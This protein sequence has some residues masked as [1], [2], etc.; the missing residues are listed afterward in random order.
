MT[1][2]P[3]EE[4]NHF[5]RACHDAA[6]RGLMRC[7]SGNLSLRL[8]NDQLLVTSSRS[9]MQDISP[10]QVSLCRISD[11]SLL[12]GNKP[13][14]EIGFHAGILRTRSDVNVVMHFQ[15][16]FATTLACQRRDVEPD[17]YVIPEIPFYIGPVARVPYLLPGTPELAQAVTTAMTDHDMVIMGNHGQV[18]VAGDIEHAIQNAEFFELACQAIVTGGQTIRPLH[19]DDVNELL[20]LRNSGQTP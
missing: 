11:A 7:S 20:A 9:W 5:V 1:D 2:I 16:P 6:H 8:D 4:L 12:Q 13:T 14:V 10:A 17:Y 15:T 3:Q 19:T 18:T